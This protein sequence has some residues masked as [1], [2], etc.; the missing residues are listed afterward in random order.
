MT[1]TNGQSGNDPDDATNRGCL[2]ISDGTNPLT[3]GFKVPFVMEALTSSKSRH[4][5]KVWREL[6]VR[7]GVCQ[8]NSISYIEQ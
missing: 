3:G 4:M 8:L 2:L 1:Y 6:L 5:P 7:H